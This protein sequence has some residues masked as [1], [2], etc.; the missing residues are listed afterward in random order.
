[1]KWRIYENLYLDEVLLAHLKQSIFKHHKPAI[2][3][4]TVQLCPQFSLAFCQ[5]LDVFSNHLFYGRRR[6]P[7]IILITR[8][9]V[10]SK[11]KR[12]CCK[13]S[14]M[15]LTSDCF[16][17]KCSIKC[18]QSFRGKYCGFCSLILIH[19]SGTLIPW[20]SILKIILHVRKHPFRW[21][22]C[23]YKC[24]QC[25]AWVKGYFTAIELAS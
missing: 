12:I 15:C 21:S 23:K 10:H 16:I 19:D 20:N 25:K 8:L 6:V 7:L 9:T 1:M 5:V 3:K 2:L 11:G 17:A 4:C 22:G 14:K 13:H 24:S 18:K